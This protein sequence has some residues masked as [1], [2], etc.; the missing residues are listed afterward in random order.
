MKTT[1]NRSQKCLVTANV[2]NWMGRANYVMGSRA[3]DLW[4][5]LNMSGWN[6]QEHR[7]Q[8][9]ISVVNMILSIKIQFQRFSSCLTANLVDFTSDM[10]R[11]ET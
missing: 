3:G 2:A 10:L 4:Y 5:W 8:C 1:G 9:S 7:V 6:D 11:D